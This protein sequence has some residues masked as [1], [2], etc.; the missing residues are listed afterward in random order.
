MQLRMREEWDVSI[1]Q[2][3]T[4]FFKHNLVQTTRTEK[5]LLDGTYKN[6]T[7]SNGQ[8]SREDCSCLS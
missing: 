7:Q 1:I 4:D 5:F 6:T 2:H 3:Q 8:T